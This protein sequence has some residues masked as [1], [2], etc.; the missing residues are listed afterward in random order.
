V[1]GA[2]GFQRFDQHVDILRRVV[3]RQAGTGRARHP[4]LFVLHDLLLE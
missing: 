1:A 3:E 4:E 2:D